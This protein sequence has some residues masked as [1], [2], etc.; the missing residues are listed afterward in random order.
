MSILVAVVSGFASGVFLR[1]LFFFGSTPLTTSDWPVIAFLFLLATILIVV[2][3]LFEGPPRTIFK[4]GALF[5][6]FAALGMLRAALAETPLPPAFASRVGERVSYDGIVVSDPDV[7]DK[8]Q[9]VEIRVAQGSESVKV[10]AVAPRSPAVAVGERVFVSG[11]LEVPEPFAAD[12]GRIFRYDKY[13]QRDGVRFLLNF[14]SIR[15]ESS[16]PWYSVPAALAKIKHAFLNGARTTLPEPYSALASGIVIGGKSS[17]GPE[18]KDAFTRSGLIHVVVLSGHN[19][20]IVA[21][22]AIAFFLFGFARAEQLIRK[23]IPSGAGPVTNR[24]SNGAGIAAGAIALVL[25]VGIAGAS[26]TAIRAALMALLALYARATGR[27]YAAGRALFAVIFLMLLWNPLYLAFDPG[28]GLSV[29]ATAG[30]IWLAPVIEERLVR[31]RV[32]R[33][34]QVQRRP[35]APKGARGSSETLSAHATGEPRPSWRNALEN[36]SSERAPSFWL[37]AVATTLSAQI[38]VLPLLLYQTGNLSLVA[39]PANLIAALLIPLAMASAYLAGF[40]GVLFSAIYPLPAVLGLPAYLVT[41]GL[42][43]IAQTSAALPFA[44]LALPAFPFWL[45]LAAYALLIYSLCRLADSK[46]F[47]TMPRLRFAKNASM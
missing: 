39:I 43:W 34:G 7:R 18:L 10:L 1:S 3:S 16:A 15:I 31:M 37:N 22:W 5:C 19:V 46:R 36:F 33:V 26:A 47:S 8:N 32:R 12:G 40:G 45:V 4:L 35:R 23:R 24:I 25:F 11:T 41:V 30:L 9:R 14:A 2:P 38:A 21:S 13:L 6:I 28:F 29:A 17:L 27:S 20:M 44:A 42:I